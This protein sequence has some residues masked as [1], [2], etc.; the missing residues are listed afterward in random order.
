MKVHQITEAPRKDPSFG[1]GAGSNTSMPKSVDIK[2]G[3]LD[4]KGNKTFNVVDQDGKVIKRFSGASAEADANVHSDKIKK[5]ISN[6]RLNRNMKQNQALGGEKDAKKSKVK[7]PK[8]PASKFTG[9][10][11][12]WVKDFLLNSTLGKLLMRATGGTIGPLL[13]TG[14]NAVKFEEALDGYMRALVNNGFDPSDDCAVAGNIDLVNGKAPSD[15][16]RAYKNCVQTL[17][18]TLI[19]IVLGIV[20]GGLS[21]WATVALLGALG[22]ASAGVSIVAGLIIGGAFI[23]GGSQLTYEVGR[24]I[25]LIDAIDSYIADTLSWTS[26]CRIANMADFAQEMTGGILGDST[27]IENKNFNKKSNSAV[28]KDLKAIIQSDPK[29]IAAF[30]KGKPKA[31]QVMAKAKAD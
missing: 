4:P 2:P 11:G 5:Q 21:I 7:P 22:I 9:L 28:I 18:E 23:V 10:V 31:K 13:T 1:I 19:E 27:V 12:R 6:D 14:L 16:L 20:F 25:G 30:N 24:A 17:S 26:M 8:G 15:L 3:I 29:L